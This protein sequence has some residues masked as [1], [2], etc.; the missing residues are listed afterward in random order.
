MMKKELK[1]EELELVNGGKTFGKP[2]NI[3]NDQRKAS[4]TDNDNDGNL[5]TKVFVKCMAWKEWLF[6]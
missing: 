2:K 4:A 3:S 6:G 5:L 1:L